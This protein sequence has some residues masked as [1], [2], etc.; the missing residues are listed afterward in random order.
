MKH[1]IQF[2]IPFL[3]LS[4]TTLAQVE[5]AK[6][7]L[8]QNKV[9]SELERLCNSSCS[10]QYSEFDQRGNMIEHNFYRVGTLYQ[11][12]YDDQDN[13]I[14]TLWIDKSDPSQIDTLYDADLK[15]TKDKNNYREESF[16]EGKLLIKY[17]EGDEVYKYIYN[18]D[19]RLILEQ[20]FKKDTLTYEESTRFDE[21]SRLLEKITKNKVRLARLNRHRTA[22][23][24]VEAII[25]RYEYNK[26]GQVTKSYSYFLDPCMNLDNHFLYVYYYHEN[27]LIESIN[28]FEMG[29]DH[30]FS[31][32]YEYEFYE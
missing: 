16:N 8:Q 21:E 24:K 1:L 30:A 27:G 11:F 9:K 19:C 32:E 25:E 2:L 10:T 14:M 17:G 26:Q 15:P 28:A 6:A 29:K 7:I 5:N 31:L 18:D 22:E 12:I 23:E 4:Q 20:R 3:F 13:K